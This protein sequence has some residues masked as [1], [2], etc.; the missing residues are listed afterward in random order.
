M[1]EN[2]KA[3]TL[4][5]MAAGMG[6]RYGGIKQIAPVGPHGELLLD[7]SVFDAVRAGFTRVVFIITRAIEQDFR[8]T[9][10]RRIERAVDVGYAFQSLDDLPDGWALPP[11][12][13]KPWG[14]VHAVLAARRI[15]HGAFAVINADDFYGA[16]AFSEMHG[17]LASGAGSAGGR[18]MRHAMVAY[19]LGNTLSEF[20][21]VT[22]GV[23][24]VD[25]ARL[26]HVTERRGIERCGDGAFCIDAEG[27]RID[28]PLDALVSMNFWG[29]DERFIARAEEDFPRFLGA[30]A[31]A[32]DIDDC[33]YL[34]PIEIDAQLAAGAAEVDVMHSPDAWHGMTYKTD[35]ERVAAAIAARH[36]SGEFPT[37][38]WGAP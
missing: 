20:G 14:T 37:P 26:T 28:L 2:D 23:C 6:S 36:E 32:G 34:L 1:S 38:L 11:S 18:V 13:S 15:L 22:R 9:A 16:A 8:E 24:E 4:V 21:G 33:E 5:V 25:G 10:G 19:R 31:A 17:W 12:R 29:L 3:V 7:Y 27:A 35:R 30:H